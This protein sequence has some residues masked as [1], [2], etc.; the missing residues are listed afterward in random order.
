M[1]GTGMSVAIRMELSG[2][3]EQFLHGNNH[4]F[5]VLVTGHAIAMIFLFVMPVIIGAF[6]KKSIIPISDMYG[7]Y[8][9]E[10]KNKFKS[11]LTASL[12]D[13]KND[14][15]LSSYNG[16]KDEEFNKEYIGSYLAGL[17]EGDGSI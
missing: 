5:N 4:L 2:P 10:I 11:Q 15:N 17:I 3:N 6:G 1:V 8:S 14:F 16:T 7:L 12:D 13:N 9:I